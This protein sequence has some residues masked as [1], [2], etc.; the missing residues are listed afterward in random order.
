MARPIMR[1]RQSAPA[2][3]RMVI[4]WWRAS[5]WRMTQGPLTAMR[6]PTEDCR[7][8][9]NSGGPTHTEITSDATAMATSTTA[10]SLRR[11]RT[12]ATW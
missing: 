12:S 6:S 10:T 11:P 7:P 8:D 9:P 1:Y 3:V 2:T 4:V 5:R